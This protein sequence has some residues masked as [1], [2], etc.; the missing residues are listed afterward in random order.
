MSAELL[1]EECDLA[2]AQPKITRC[3]VFSQVDT[4]A[5]SRNQ[6]YVRRLASNH[7]SAT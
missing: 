6:Q 2:I 1:V 3:K 7:A 5:R 4:S